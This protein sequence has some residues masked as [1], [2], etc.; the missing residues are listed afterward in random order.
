MGPGDV[1]IQGFY[2][3]GEI[4]GG[5]HGNNRLGGSSLLEFLWDY[6]QL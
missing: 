6:F 3:A 2:A 4:A 1:P 5:V